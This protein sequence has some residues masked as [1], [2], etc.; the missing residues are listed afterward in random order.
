MT[1]GII[2]HLV[3]LLQF[4]TS[5]NENSLFNGNLGSRSLVAL[6]LTLETSL[7]LLKLCLFPVEPVLGITVLLTSLV[8]QLISLAT[9]LN[10]ILPLEVKLMALSM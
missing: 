4:F 1:V 6:L 2:L 5:H 3:S 9:V 7:V 8:D 10:G